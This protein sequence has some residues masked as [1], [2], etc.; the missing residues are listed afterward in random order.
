MH[1]VYL[2]SWLLGLVG[3]TMLVAHWMY[4]IAGLLDLISQKCPCSV[5]TESHRKAVLVKNVEELRSESRL[6]PV[7][8]A[9][10]LNGDVN[11]DCEQASTSFIVAVACPTP[12]QGVVIRSPKHKQDLVHKYR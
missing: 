3:L 11:E 5:K 6:S 2:S 9:V 7:E 12:S 1:R 4:M 10:E 8:D